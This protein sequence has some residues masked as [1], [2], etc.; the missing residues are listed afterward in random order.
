MRHRAT[1]FA[2]PRPRQL[3]WFL[4]PVVLAAALLAPRVEAQEKLTYLTNWY[5]QAEHGG[6][7]QAV[8]TGLYRKHGLDVTVRMGGPQ[9]NGQQ[10]LAAGQVDFIMGYDMQVLKAIEQDVPL[11]T[12]AASFQHDPT[13]VLAH[14]DVPGL[15]GLR[16]RTILVSTSGMTTWWP[17]MKAKYGYTDD[18][19]RPYTFN[20]QPFFADRKVAQ[21]A[22]MS[23][24]PFAAEKAGVKAKFFLLAKEG[25]PPYATTIVAM[26]KLVADKPDVVARFVRASAEGWKS[27]LANPGPGNEL[28]KQANPNMKDDQLAYAIAKLKETGMITGGDAATMGIGVMTDERWKK[29]YEYMVSQRLLKPEVDYRRGFTTQFVKDLRVM[30]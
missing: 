15:D 8:A 2:P 3:F 19:V 30:P 18:Q 17:W 10:I 22:Y 7:Y 9:V 1:F 29:T 26:Q 14:D 21:S 13:G 24:E 23:S 6:F 16:G 5:A 12:V 25:Y 20:L 4:M 11:V 27:Y 28:I